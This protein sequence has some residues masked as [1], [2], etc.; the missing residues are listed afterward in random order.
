VSGQFAGD[1][2]I[3][4]RDQGQLFVVDRGDRQ[5]QQKHR[6]VGSGNLQCRAKSQTLAEK[7]LKG[8]IHR[9]ED[10]FLESLGRVYVAADLV[11]LGRIQG[12]PTAAPIRAQKLEGSRR[13]ERRRCIREIH[14]ADGHLT[15][16]DRAQGVGR[17]ALR[18]RGP[19]HRP[20]RQDGC[21]GTK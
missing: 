17:D 6:C 5:P 4:G 7:R 14:V 20:K 2:R 21:A 3:V 10:E 18:D 12:A 8:A 16:R 19:E 11:A 15:D 1:G 13:N 9:L